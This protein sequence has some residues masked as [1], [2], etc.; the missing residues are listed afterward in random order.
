ME[1]GDAITQFGS[2][3]EHLDSLPETRIYR[4]IDS[5]VGTVRSGLA[6]RN[7]VSMTE[8]YAETRFLISTGM[9]QRNRAF[10]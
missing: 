2:D 3:D 5:E 4:F 7:R 10:E 1:S 9:T 8:I 6:Q